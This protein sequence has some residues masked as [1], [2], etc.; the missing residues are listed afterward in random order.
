MPL[1]PV[2]Q[3]SLNQTIDVDFAESSAPVAPT[4]TAANETL[5]QAA[6]GSAKF[7]NLQGQA[8]SHLTLKTS[9]P[10]AAQ[11]ALSHEIPVKLSALPNTSPALVDTLENSAARSASVSAST[12]K[13]GDGLKLQT[14]GPPPTAT[15]PIESPKAGSQGNSNG[16]S[17]A[18]T[19][20]RSDHNS[21][22][23]SSANSSNSSN[24]QTGDKGF[25]QT[26]DAA[27][28][29]P[30]TGHVTPPDPTSI[31]AATPVPPQPAGSSGQAVLA[32]AS[33][34][35][36]PEPLPAP[37]EGAS[38]VNSAHIVVQPGQ[39]EIRIEMQ[40]ESLGG[41]ELRAHIA[42]DQ[43]GASISVEHHDAQ[44]ALTT[45]LPALHNAL[46]EKNLRLESLTVSQGSFS[47]LSGGLGH[48]TSQKGF[49]NP[50]SPG[51]FTFPDRQEM[52]QLPKESP[53]EWT[54]SSKRGSGLS[55][56]A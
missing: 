48:D 6:R 38:V 16:S 27:A 55:V 40:A 45:D 21:S 22:S 47:A 42:G 31:A 10:S 37:S 29:G 53:V 24:I 7:L 3:P 8:P 52:A 4:S 23:S 35:H 26:L 54:V 36:S 11:P 41:V 34:A 15:G 12:A 5:I 46:A 49:A 2:A 30:S 18:D 13:F 19:N 9:L 17:S 51:K 20:S 28:S 50:Q 56:V 14:D 32:N 1:S 33:S 44:I 25:V 39:T 43:I